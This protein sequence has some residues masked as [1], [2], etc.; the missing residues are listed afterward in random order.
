MEAAELNHEAKANSL[1]E[2][3]KD[4][5]LHFIVTAHPADIPGEARG[6]GSN[7]SFAARHGCAQMIQH[8]IDRRRVVITVSDSDSSIPELYVKEVSFFFFLPS[9]FFYCV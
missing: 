5:F 7:V 2:Y 4:S 6:K 9:P 3:F 1:T 8:G